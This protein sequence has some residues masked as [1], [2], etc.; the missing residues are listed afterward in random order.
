MF[1]PDQYWVPPQPPQ[2]ATTPYEDPLS[3]KLDDIEMELATLIL[4][5]PHEEQKSIALDFSLQS[6]LADLTLALGYEN[7]KNTST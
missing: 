5:R 7:C 2:N 6:A 4:L 1:Q 3:K